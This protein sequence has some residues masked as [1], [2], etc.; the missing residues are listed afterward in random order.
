M[1]RYSILTK[2]LAIVLCAVCL[3]VCVA[4]S[5]GILL[6]EENGLYTNGLESWMDSEAR[7]IGNQIAYCT[8]TLYAAEHLGDCTSDIL[9]TL[10]AD[11][12]TYSVDR[13]YWSASIF[14]GDTQLQKGEPVTGGWELSYQIT[15]HYPSPWDEEDAAYLYQE[16]ILVSNQYT[17]EFYH[18]DLAYHQG[19]TYQVVVFLH[20]QALN[21][22]R[23]GFMTMLYNMRYHFITMLV[24]GLLCFAAALVLLCCIAGRRPNSDR[25]YPVALNRLPLDLYAAIIAAAEVGLSY[26]VLEMLQAC[27]DYGGNW[28]VASLIALGV[29]VMAVLVVA[30]IFAF[31]AQMKT[32][33]GFW[34]RRTVIGWVL[35]RIVRAI[36][37]VGRGFRALFQMMPLVWQWLLIIVGV[38]LSA[39]LSLIVLA[40]SYGIIQI[41]AILVFLASILGFFGLIAYWGYCMGHLL[42]GITT[43][44]GGNLLYQIPTKRLYGKFRDFGTALNSM[45]DAARI[46]AQRQL[47]SERMKTELITNVSHDIKTPL[48]S[49][50]NYVDLLQKPHDEAQ[51]E[52]YLEVLSRQSLRL[53][54]LIDDLMDLSKAST[55]NLNVEMDYVDA[56]EA[57]N[58]ALGE[59]SDKLD[60][61]ALYPV[62]RHPDAPVVIQADGRL[63]WRVMSNLLSNAVKY[64]MPGTRVYI[65]LVTAE[66]TAV[67]QMKNISRDQLNINA[68]EL[69]E[70]FVRGDAA[71][72]TEG[73]G[74]GLNIAKSLVELQKGQMH[75][76]VDGDL[77]KVT[78]VLP[79]AQE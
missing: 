2:F 58:Q 61:A 60:R 52:Q 37:T 42:K 65:D 7:M 31:A 4:G 1:L 32:K 54:K 62:F 43:M 79:L 68:D 59:F 71:R 40:N 70:R 9:K 19:P 24:V 8:A 28:A 30:F 75:L 39:V 78:I 25:V 76:M 63:L 67:L 41:L 23:V 72:N 73:S 45:A 27:F 21:S 77:F 34:W 26:L 5:F 53:K 35:V 16:S 48:T 14:L 36:R 12:Y 57:I 49:I 44:A 20:P 6:N 46:A 64:A 22:F 17:G 29:F 50:I 10:E 3:V 69:L 38:L 13:A 47:K 56:V 66:G 11:F 74:L 55:G 15:P 51:G 33:G 18:V